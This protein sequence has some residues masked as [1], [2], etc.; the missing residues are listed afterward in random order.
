M[1][2]TFKNAFSYNSAKAAKGLNELEAHLSENKHALWFVFPYTHIGGAEK[3]HANIVKVFSSRNPI[4][5]FTGKSKDEKF[6]DLFSSNATVFNIPDTLYHPSTGKKAKELILKNINL[7]TTPVLFGANSLYFFDLLNG[8]S[9]QTKCINLIHAF[10]FDPQGNQNEKK[11]LAISKRINNTVFISGQALND[12]KKLLLENHFGEE[13]I[14]RLIYIPNYITIGG[15][16][17]KPNA[18]FTV[19]FVGRNSPEKRFNLFIETAKKVRATDP[20][21]KF[22]AVGISKTEYPDVNEVAFTGEVTGEEKLK[23][24]YQTAHVLIICSNREGFPMVIM[25]AMANGVIPIS[26]AVGDIPNVLNGDNGILINSEK[27]IAEQIAGKINVLIKDEEL[28]NSL[29]KNAHHYA[30]EN[31]TEHHFTEAYLKLLLSSK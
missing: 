9:S 18:S 23:A 31:F 25:E 22:I 15:Y 17:S 24:I 19:L 16:K 21:I 1:L 20:T 30:S 2:R 13:D 3:V 5:L 26:T 14:K 7:N 27:D 28:R 29:S 6:I 8:V 4:V 10:K 12:Y 11:H